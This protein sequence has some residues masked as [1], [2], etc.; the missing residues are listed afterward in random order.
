MTMTL[1]QLE[2]EGKIRTHRTSER[3]ISDLFKLI[4]RDMQDA[5]SK[6]IS[7]DRRFA[8]IY[9]AALALA[10]VLLSCKGYQSYGN[11]HHFTIFQC[12]KII[13]GKDYK[14]Y[15]ELADYFDSCRV[16]RNNLDYDFAGAVSE[17]EFHELMDEVK[18]FYDF[19]KAWVKKH[20]PQYMNNE[21]GH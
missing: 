19:V 8:T 21:K 12:M 18:K 11:A 6:S 5:S 7:T 13:L 16:K 9:N 10:T 4:K 3:E 20:Y 1:R 14:D 17:K 2:Q 15:V